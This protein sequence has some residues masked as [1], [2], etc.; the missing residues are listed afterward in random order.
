MDSDLQMHMKML[1]WNVFLLAP[2]ME[3]Y[4]R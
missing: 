2:N 3:W 1:L 4:F